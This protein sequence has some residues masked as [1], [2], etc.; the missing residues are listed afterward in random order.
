MQIRRSATRVRTVAAAIRVTAHR[1]S[2]PTFST[3]EDVPLSNLARDFRPRSSPSRVHLT[4]S[5]LFPPPLPRFLISARGRGVAQ[6]N[7]L[8]FAPLGY[9]RLFALRPRRSEEI[10]SIDRLQPWTLLPGW[11]RST[12]RKT[13]DKV[14]KRQSYLRAWVRSTTRRGFSRPPW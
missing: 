7:P 12:R 1:H 11:D 2:Q 5:I 4:T 9:L 10:S 6:K 14:I 13:C 8:P 3:P